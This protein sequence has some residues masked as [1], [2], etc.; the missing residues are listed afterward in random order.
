M[1][2]I[3]YFLISDFGAGNL[4]KGEYGNGCEGQKKGSKSIAHILYNEVG[5]YGIFTLPFI[6]IGKK[7]V[8]AIYF[9]CAIFKASIVV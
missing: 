8:L 3:K 2:K 9:C 1:R 6:N 7:V 5:W 4:K